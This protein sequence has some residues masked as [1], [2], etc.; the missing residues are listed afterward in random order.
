[1]KKFKRH[2]ERKKNYYLVSSAIT[3]LFIALAVVA[4]VCVFALASHFSWYL[5]MTKG[6]VFSLCDA[7]KDFLDEVDAE[8]NIYFTV[9]AD[10][11]ASTSQYLYNV[12]R[13]ALEM[14]AQYDNI[15]V[16]CID[17]V[18]NPGFFKPF[19]QTHA[20]KIYTDSVVIE[21]GSESRIYY[22]DSFFIFDENGEYIWA[23][24]GEYKLVSAILSMT[25]AEMPPVYFTTQ[26]GEKV[27]GDAQALVNLFSDA[28]FEVRQI[29]LTKEEISDDA[30]I[31]IINDP[32]Y[33]FAGINSADD[34]GNEIAKLDK[35]LDN[36]GCLMVFS[37]PENAA[38]LTNL[39]EF[40]S[41]WGIAFTPDTYIKDT[42]NAVST[43]GRALVAKYA[44]AESL[45]G[46]LYSDITDLDSAPKTILK[47]AMPLNIL[48]ESN[49]ELNGNKDVDAVLLSNDT[50]VSVAN[51]EETAVG[52][53]PL[54]VVSR[55][56][57]IV[58]NE[59]YYSYVLACGTP[60][61]ASSSYLT[62]NTYANSDIIYNAIKLTGRERILADIEYKVL[63]ETDL[64][65]TTAQA[66]RWTVAVTV[67]LPV[68]VAV[69]GIVVTVRRK[70]A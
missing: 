7:T 33:D 34:N 70:N 24:Q 63:D 46:S 29:D 64:D 36:L 3:A 23:Y 45:G 42:A 14:E 10:K 21:S 12:Y 52:S 55:E 65:I 20:Q 51:G 11:V 58:N 50:A 54:M 66:N 15:N 43:D 60:D 67:T 27:G 26:H 18:K 4:N 6:Q 8:V 16:E 32:V 38:N 17:I 61:F 47:N 28:G 30:R 31:V 62:S 40:L 37:S 25:D 22:I 39:S 69:C 5:D 41:E 13:T 57:T 48:F 53:V 9:E 35:F 68:I 59:Y 44:D 2:N 1:M 56:N 19:Y 49:S